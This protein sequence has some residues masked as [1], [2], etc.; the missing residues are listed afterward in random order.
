MQDMDVN[1]SFTAQLFVNNT[2]IAISRKIIEKKLAAPEVSEYW[3][4][5]F[6]KQLIY[7]NNLLSY[8]EEVTPETFLFA[9][10]DDV[11][12]IKI[13]DENGQFTN[14]ASMEGELRN[15]TVFDGD[16]PTYFRIIYQGEYAKLDDM[17]N[18]LN[19]IR[20]R[21]GPQHREVLTYG[22]QPSFPVLT[23]LKNRDRTLF[24]ELKILQ[25]HVSSTR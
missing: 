11:Y 21:S 5:V 10:H 18:E 22:D 1:Q 3:A 7:S 15:L 24:L 6:R 2:P 4:G 20:L 12:T 23:D 16:D 9:Y 13:A 8:G 14:T 19:R 25:R 17:P